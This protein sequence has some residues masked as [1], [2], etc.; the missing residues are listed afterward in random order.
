[1]GVWL[2]VEDEFR[3][4]ARMLAVGSEFGEL[5]FHGS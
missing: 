4:I 5:I 3:I 1:M 2:V